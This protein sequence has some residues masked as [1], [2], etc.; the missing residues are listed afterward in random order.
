MKKY[1]RFFLIS[2]IAA[3]FLIKCTPL[4]NIPH[5]VDIEV[6]CDKDTIN[7]YT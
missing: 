7:D 4:Y 5:I 6:Y 2:F 1:T 3:V